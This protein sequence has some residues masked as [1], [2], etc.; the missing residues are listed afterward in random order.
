MGEASAWGFGSPG[1]SQARV[2]ARVAIL[3]SA[4]IRKWASGGRPKWAAS[5]PA[6]APSSAPTLKKP[7]SEVMMLRPEARSAS[8]PC[9]FIETSSEPL[10]APKRKRI[11]MMTS[12]RG[13]TAM[14]GKTTR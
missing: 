8:L 14:K 5:A 3:S 9:A 6:P 13:A 2:R 7:C 1:M 11:G 12:R 10:P 4:T